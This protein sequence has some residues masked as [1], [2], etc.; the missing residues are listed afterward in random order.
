MLYAE[1][2]PE[3]G[4]SL[5]ADDLQRAPLSEQLEAPLALNNNPQTFSALAGS[6]R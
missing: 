6:S 1:C 4:R 2:S 5:I 3:P